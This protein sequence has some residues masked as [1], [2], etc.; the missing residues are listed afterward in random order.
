[1]ADKSRGGRS[2]GNAKDS[3]DK[4][5]TEARKDAEADVGLLDSPDVANEPSEVRHFAYFA[6]VVGFA[7]VLN[8]VAMILAAGGQ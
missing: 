2:S 1:M 6:A 4:K 5:M 8:L 3:I 7:I